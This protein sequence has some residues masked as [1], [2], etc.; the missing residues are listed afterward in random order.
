MSTP[1]DADCPPAK[2][3]E[4]QRVPGAAPGILLPPEGSPEPVIDVVISGDNT[5]TLHEN[6]SVPEVKRLYEGLGDQ[7]WIWVD[8]NGLADVEVISGLGEVFGFHRLSLEDALH[9]RQRPK[10]DPYEGYQ[11]LVVQVPYFQE[12][13][14]D[15]EQVS[16]FV[17]K[18][19]LVSMQAYRVNQLEALYKRIGRKGGRLIHSRTDYL[20]YAALDVL[21]DQVFPVLA[22][23]DEGV[24]A[25]ED[26]LLTAA[27]RD[28]VAE[29][30][31][32][33]GD[34]T[35]LRRM[36]WNQVLLL[37]HLMGPG[38]DWIQKE[39][40]PYFRDVLDHAE[41]AL[42]LSEQQR[43]TCS[44]LFEL[45][46][47]VNSAQMNEIIKVLTIISTIFIP[48]TFIAGIYGMNFENMPELKWAGGYVFA[49]GLMFLCAGGMV[50]MF[51]RRG[52]IGGSGKS[53][54]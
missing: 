16:L 3:S 13:V 28:R 12:E 53:E 8:V 49:W 21:V 24:D 40:R 1:S 43:E 2:V 26:Q 17:G 35:S 47:S 9:L 29:I 4:P 5:R 54:E 22:R 36:L 38:P 32:L 27:G 30:H 14:L 37:Q 23:L 44:G 46:N 52:W 18:R 41:R 42:G 25:L 19:F 20:A 6:V 45:H 11:Y 34:V 51:H 10:A 7:Q 15:F 48:L 33:R 50:V 39:T 31:R